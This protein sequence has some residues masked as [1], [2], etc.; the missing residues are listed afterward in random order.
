M[1][2]LLWL[3][4][5]LFGAPQPLPPALAQWRAQGG[6][7]LLFAPDDDFALLVAALPR[8][9]TIALDFPK[10]G[11]GRPYS[12]VALLRGR[13]GWRGEL[14]AAGAVQIDQL[15]FMRRVGFDSVAAPAAWRS[16]AAQRAITAALTSFSDAY[17]AAADQPLPA[18]RRHRRPAASEQPLTPLPSVAPAAPRAFL[19]DGAGATHTGAGQPQ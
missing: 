7:D 2:E 10:A 12:L 15:H 9:A 5:G 1:P 14:R 19:F 6:A 17:Q 3:A 8:L 4:E 11:D 18:W 13:H 16:A